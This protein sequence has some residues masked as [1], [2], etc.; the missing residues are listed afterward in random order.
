MSHNKKKLIVLLVIGMSFGIAQRMLGQDLHD[1]SSFQPHWTYWAG[2]VV[3]FYTV[4]FVI[5]LKCPKCNK[6]QVLFRGSLFNP[7]RWPGDKCFNCG[8]DL[9]KKHE[10]YGDNS[11]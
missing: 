11:N 6:N 8:T 2:M 4:Y 9:R 3:L 1:W 5:T 10:N 7:W